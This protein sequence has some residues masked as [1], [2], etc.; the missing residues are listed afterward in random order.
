MTDN[1][2]YDGFGAVLDY[3]ARVGTTQAL[4]TQFTRDKLGRI[5]RKIETVG[6]VVHTYEYSYDLAARLE[7]VKQN[8][9]VTASYTYDSNGNRLT[10][11]N[12]LNNVIYDM[13][14][15]L[16]SFGTNSYTYTANGEMLT[17]LNGSKTTI[18]QYDALGNLLKVSLPG[19]E[20]IEYLIDGNNRRIGKKVNGALVHG[21]LYQGSLSPIAEL[22]SRNQIVSRFVYANHINVPDYMIKGGTTYRIITD[23]LGSPRLVVN[24]TTGN[25]VQRIDYD[26]YGK[27]LNDSN[28]GFQPFGFGGG[29]YDQDTKLVHF[30]VREY[31]TEIGRWTAKDPLLFAPGEPNVYVYA[32]NDPL[33]RIDP[34]GKRG[35]TLGSN[36]GAGVL[37]GG[38]VGVGLGL[39]SERGLFFYNY[40]QGGLHVGASI[41][42]GIEGMFYRDFNKLEGPGNEVGINLPAVGFAVG[43]E[44]NSYS[45]TLGP[46]LGADI[47][48]YWNYTGTTYKLYD[49]YDLQPWPDPQG[50]DG[51]SSTWDP[52]MSTPFCECSK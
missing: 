43:S 40:A 45:I 46:S 2:S 44:G 7:Q 51:G 3:T 22:N 19:G 39:D 34:N 31:D 8:G 50:Y 11:P 21:F 5:T 32:S 29:L 38:S 37:A 9:L 52:P 28:P 6:G 25:I 13:Q 49:E 20:I 16:T 26:E 23:Q 15:R 24:V 33:N 1:I 10:G 41:G 47:H 36:A 48:G 14:D 42:C 27:V 30:G 17:K 12:G 4:S 18:Y 35:L